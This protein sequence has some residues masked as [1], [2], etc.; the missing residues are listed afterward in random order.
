MALSAGTR[1]GPYEVLARLGEGGAAIT[2]V[3]NWR[4]ELNGR[5]DTP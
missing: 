2:V 5:A 3:L 4:E 1:I